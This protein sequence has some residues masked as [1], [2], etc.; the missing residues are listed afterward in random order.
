MRQASQRLVTTVT[1]NPASTSHPVAAKTRQTPPNCTLANYGKNNKWRP[2]PTVARSRA[3]KSVTTCSTLYFFL[4]SSPFS[5]SSYP[6]VPPLPHPLRPSPKTLKQFGSY[7]KR[8]KR[9]PQRTKQTQKMNGLA[10]LGATR[11]YIR[12]ERQRKKLRF[13]VLPTRTAELSKHPP[14]SPTRYHLFLLLP[15]AQE[16][17]PSLLSPLPPPRQKPPRTA[18]TDAEIPPPLLS[19]SS[20]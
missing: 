1:P 9:M 6:A 13:I 11:T 2:Q 18:G 12:T 3:A 4:A 20:C 10:P 5:T 8:R 19:L 16:G 17:C 15:S 7:K 14:P